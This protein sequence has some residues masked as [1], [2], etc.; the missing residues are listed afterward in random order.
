MSNMATSDKMI[1]SSAAWAAGYTG[2]GSRIA[3]I[4]TGADVMWIIPR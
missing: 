1:G 2:A 4:D 3:I